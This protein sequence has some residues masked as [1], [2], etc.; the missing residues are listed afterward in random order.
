MRS[1]SKGDYLKNLYKSY[2]D[3]KFSYAIVEDI[4]KEDAF[5]EVVKAGDF[6]GILHTASPFHV[7]TRLLSRR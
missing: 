7:R 5:D 4:E 2:G 3:D 1:S 6:D